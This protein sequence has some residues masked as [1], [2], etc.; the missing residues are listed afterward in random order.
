MLIAGRFLDATDRVRLS[1]LDSAPSSA[2]EF[3]S[4]TTATNDAPL[5]GDGGAQSPLVSHV[6]RPVTAP[7]QPK[8]GGNT[9]TMVS[10]NRGWKLAE[11]WAI[12]LRLN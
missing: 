8:R 6:A 11:K 4:P 9:H 1:I 10:G 3:D 5:L 2:A 7:C 12:Y